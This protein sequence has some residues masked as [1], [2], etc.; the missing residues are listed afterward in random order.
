MLSG[1]DDSSYSGGSYNG[2]IGRENIA[3]GIESSVGVSGAGV[4]VVSVYDDVDI[5]SSYESTSESPYM[6]GGGGVYRYYSESAA[7]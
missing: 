3:D 5:G 1:S 7:S 2:A 4:Y 6:Y